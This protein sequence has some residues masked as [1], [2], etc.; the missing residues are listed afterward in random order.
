MT[1]EEVVQIGRELLYTRSVVGMSH[2]AGE[3]RGGTLH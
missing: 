1:P 2:C 3:S